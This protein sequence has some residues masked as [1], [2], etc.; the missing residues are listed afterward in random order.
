MYT[1]VQVILLWTRAQVCNMLKSS[2]LF[3]HLMITHLTCSFSLNMFSQSMSL[4]HPVQLAEWIWHFSTRDPLNYK[5]NSSWGVG[6]SSSF[7]Q[8]AHSKTI[9][10]VLGQQGARDAD[11]A[12]LASLLVCCSL[13]SSQ[14][15]QPLSENPRKPLL[16]PPGH[17]AACPSAHPGGSE[18][19][20]PYFLR[21]N[22]ILCL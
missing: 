5:W 18:K 9:C 15:Q 22:H 8:T 1:L 7:K 3:Q 10:L 12:S 21:A 13:G 19:G 4:L 17:A 11:G 16:H 20:K 2:A 14:M 6:G